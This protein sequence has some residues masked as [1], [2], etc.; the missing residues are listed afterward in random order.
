[1]LGD[2]MAA[3]LAPLGHARAAPD[4]KQH[5]LGGERAAA[6]VRRRRAR[7]ACQVASAGE[8]FARERIGEP[9]AVHVHGKPRLCAISAGGIS[10]GR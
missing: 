6:L 4:R 9:G 7:R 5:R 3:A 2:K 1:M 8:A 10:S